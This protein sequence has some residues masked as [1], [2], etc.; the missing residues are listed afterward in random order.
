VTWQGLVH[1]GR[2]RRQVVA[3]HPAPAVLRN[4]AAQLWRHGIGDAFRAIASSL[5]D[6]ATLFECSEGTRRKHFHV[7]HFVY[8]L[9][10]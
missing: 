8:T 9:V 3:R 6:L 4:G 2:V 1:V 5:V 7:G 10:I